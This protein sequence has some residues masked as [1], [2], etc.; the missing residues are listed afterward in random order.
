MYKKIQTVIES[1][2]TD[3]EQNQKML[4][5][6]KRLYEDTYLKTF[7]SGMIAS[8]LGFPKIDLASMDIVTSEITEKVFKTKK[9]VPI[10]IK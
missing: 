4:L 3:F 7:P 6:K 10:K 8:I 1:G 9:S 5:D 2:R